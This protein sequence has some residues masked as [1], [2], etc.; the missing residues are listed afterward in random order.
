MRREEHKKIARLQDI[1]VETLYRVFSRAVIHG[2]TSIWR[3]YSGNR[4]SEDVDA[5]IE[6]DPARTERFFEELKRAGF[7]TVKRRTTKN[8]LYSVLS[9]GGVEVRFEALFK[10][11][12]GVVKEYETYEGILLNV[13]TLL[14]E[15]MVAEKIEA[16]LKR[17]KVRDL[18][19]IFFMLRHVQVAEGVKPVL[20][21]LLQNFSD[22]VDEGELK[23][24]IMFGAIPSK[25]DI[26][27]YLR[28]WA[29]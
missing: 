16:Y 12:E 26:V 15:E 1:I 5:Y 19:D 27:E 18:Y 29:A 2:G 28:R 9:L 6:R 3:C 11:V 4:F 20:A 22:P 25:E 23:A 8:S 10:C 17:R 14:P 7:E 13:F 24:L 21:R